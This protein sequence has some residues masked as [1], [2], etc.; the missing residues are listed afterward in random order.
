MKQH[1]TTF[2]GKIIYNTPEKIQIT[3]LQI[4]KQTFQTGASKLSYL[5]S[6]V[7]LAVKTYMV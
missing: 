6:C 1:S 7:Y 3:R 5:V 4:Q 2:F